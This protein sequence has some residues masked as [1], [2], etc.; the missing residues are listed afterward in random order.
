MLFCV[1]FAFTGKA[2]Q[3]KGEGK[4]KANG[5]QKGKARYR[6]GKARHDIP[7]QV[8]INTNILSILFS[9]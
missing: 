6:K 5:M 1:G 8:K 7:E 4:G 2:R 9:P 3:D